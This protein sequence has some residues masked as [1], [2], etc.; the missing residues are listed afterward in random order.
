MNQQLTLNIEPETTPE[1]IQDMIQRSNEEELDSSPSVMPPADIVAFNE[2]RSCA[3]IFRMYQK[4]QIEIS[5]DFQRGE[6][7]RNSAQ[8][9][10]IDSLIK[11]LPI[12]SMC[13]S[14]DM[15]SQKRMVIDGLQ[16]ISSIIKF[17]DQQKDWKLSKSDDVDSRISGKKVSEIR[18]ENAKLVEVLEN[19]TIPITVLRC[20]YNKEEHM[21]YLF[22]I[23]FR[24]NSGGN[25]LYNQEIRNCI[26]QGSFNTLLKE[27]AR[28]PE[29]CRFAN[30]DQ[31]KVDKA[32]FNNEERILRFFAFYE[33]RSNYKGK[34][35]SF[36]NSY[37][38][39]NKNLDDDKIGHFRNLFVKTL[40]VANK[41]REKVDSKKVDSKNVAEAVMIGIASNIET[42]ENKDP[43]TLDQM[44]RSLL[45][46]PR[47]AA[48]EMK[49]GLSSEEKV[50]GRIDSAINAF[51]RG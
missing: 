44:Y 3:D 33:S 17:L 9:L 7:W 24:L 40:E 16:R 29:W 45:D 42:L 48:E 37:M 46:H 47:F 13:I 12:P 51:S 1:E 2:Q 14:L 26:F 18:I 49:E 6:V 41:L 31:G 43:E 38:N 35:A 15:S 39:E 28:T 11:Q 50:N 23:F 27:L 36:L 4:G 8:T 19:V 32:R 25:K 22:Q 10:F 21:K 34:L 30:T 5:P 20:D